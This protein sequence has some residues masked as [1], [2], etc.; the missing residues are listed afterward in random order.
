MVDFKPIMLTESKLKT[1]PIKQGQLIVITDNYGL[2]L[3]VTAKIRKSIQQI[4]SITEAERNDMLVP[5]TGF[6]HISDKNKLYYY[7]SD[8]HMIGGE[9]IVIK[10]SNSNGYINV[11]GQDILVYSPTDLAITYTAQ[12]LSALKSGELLTIAMGKIK[13]AVDNLIT[14]LTSYANPHK[15]SKSQ[16]GLSKVENMSSNDILDLIN[17]DHIINALGYEPPMQDTT[18]KAATST[19][20]GL[21]KSGNHISVGADGTVT[22]VGGYAT[23]LAKAVNIAVSGAVSGTVSFN[24]ASDVTINTTLA[25]VPASKITG[26][27]SI[28]NIP[29][30]AIERCAVVKNDTERFAL[31][32]ANI[33][34]GDTVKVGTGDN[35]KMYLVVDDTKLSTEDGYEIYRAG[36]AASVPWAGITGKPSVF[37][38][39]AHTHTKAQITDFPTSMPASDVST[40]AKAATKPSYTP[41]EIGVISSAPVSGQV[42]VFDGTTGKIKSTGFTIAKS[43]P[44][45]AKFT[46]TIYSHPVY[47]A[48]VSGLYKVTIDDTGHVS[49]TT[50][51]TKTDIT[52]LGIPAQD[53]NTTYGLATS[54]TNGLIKIG[55]TASGKN[56]PV[57]LD[58]DGKAYVN[59]PWTDTTYTLA[60]LG[61]T[62]TATELNY[63]NGVTSNIQ[64]QLDG[65]ALAKHSHTKSEITDFPTA[66][67]NPTAIKFTGAV[68]GT[69]D[70]SAELTLN[71]PKADVSI[72]ETD[73]HW[74]IGGADTGIVAEGKKGEP[75]NN[76]TSVTHSWDGTKLTITSASGVSS[77]DLKGQKGDTGEIGPQ[78]PAGT[79]DFNNLSNKPTALKNPQALTINGTVYDGSEAK[80]VTISGNWGGLSDKPDMLNCM[81]MYGGTKLDATATTADTN[82][83]YP[84]I[85]KSTGTAATLF[86]KE[87][88]DL[89]KGSYSV[90]VRM[91]VS[92][93]SSTANVFKLEVKDGTAINTRYI[94]PSMFSV[95][96]GYTTIG[97]VVE[98]SNTSLTVTLS[99]DTALASQTVGVDYL[100]I[101]PAMNGLASVA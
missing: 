86:T 30:G 1:L 67:K 69:Y 27:L 20:L 23:Q 35:A 44:A 29:Q 52:A 40:W 50:A 8:W 11:N 98:H 97:F 6:Y 39:E 4:F 25:N 81:R 13:V 75:G 84:I 28:D 19:V 21:V 85:S 3:D 42:A 88:S 26:V 99:I 24:G 87:L 2:Y 72:R 7:D 57:V 32:T 47:T 16:V 54:T 78:G 101:A 95:A 63:S 48:K 56:Y 92:A 46:D 5:V 62:A 76:G 73:K 14:H 79:T 60:T 64:T 93:I 74:I 38:P 77:A 10:K 65:K 70:G 100:L 53:T 61:V 43:V 59:V 68:T 37:S 51:V 55:Y 89:P 49:A 91:K 33:Q 22:V 90:M 94:K 12:E 15:V 31:T 80:S 82:A 17:Y 96:N 58:S 71:I 18:Y 36:S 45:D 66:L 83:Q 34:K 41:T 9:D